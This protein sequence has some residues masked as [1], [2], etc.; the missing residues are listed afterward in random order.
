MSLPETERALKITRVFDAP[1]ELVFKV[2]TN[3]DTMLGWWG[4]KLHPAT[5][6]QMD[7]RPGGKWRGCLTGVED[8]R[9]L[10]QHGVFREVNPHH[11]LAFT[12]VWEEEGERGIETLVTIRFTDEN[13]KTRMDFHQTPFQSVAE[14]EGHQGGWSS[15]F[16]RLAEYLS[17]A[18]TTD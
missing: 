10:W 15:M 2:W 14:R 12:F 5:Q 17:A 3:P 6:M 13:G 11:H 9:A 18:Q 1:R 8:G 7:V 4:P 16:D